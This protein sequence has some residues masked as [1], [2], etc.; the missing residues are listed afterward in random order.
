MSMGRC[1][2][3]RLDCQHALFDRAKTNN[4]NT[5][6]IQKIQHNRELLRRTWA[7]GY[8]LRWQKLTP[9]ANTS[10]GRL[11]AQL[12]QLHCLGSQIWNVLK[13]LDA[14]FM[15]CFGFF[16]HRQKT[17]RSMFFF[18]KHRW[19]ITS[20][21][22]KCNVLQDV[23]RF[24]K[25]HSERPIIVHKFQRICCNFHFI[26]FWNCF[27]KHPKYASWAGCFRFLQTSPKIASLRIWKYCIVKKSEHRSPLVG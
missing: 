8:L 15:R 21:S 23:F 20:L 16:K 27:Q 24:Q 17:L 12:P 13:L 10:G 9:S 2:F 7:S 14:P 22:K 5:Q 19:N 4:P 25:V 3:R 1:V 11:T 26:S 6:E 18:S